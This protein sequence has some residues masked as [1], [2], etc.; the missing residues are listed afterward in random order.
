MVLVLYDCFLFFLV[1]EDF[2]LVDSGEVELFKGDLD[3][4]C[5]WILKQQVVEK[6]KVNSDVKNE[7]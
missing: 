2:Y 4:Y 6:V 1:C 3:D 5:D 7:E